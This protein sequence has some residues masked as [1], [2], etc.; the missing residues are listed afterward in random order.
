MLFALKGS[1]S[2]WCD[3]QAPQEANGLTAR[4]EAGEPKDESGR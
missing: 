1:C 4:K 2:D 3:L